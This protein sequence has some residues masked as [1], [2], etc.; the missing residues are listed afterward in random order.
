MGLFFGT[1]GLRGEFRKGIT[2]KISFKVGN[3]LGVL[4][5]NGKVLIATDTRKS[6]D[7]L[8]LSFASGLMLAGASVTFVGVCPTA[9]VG[10]LCARNRFD[11]GVVISASHNSAEFNG[12]KIFDKNGKKIN[13]NIESEIERNLLVLKEK[14]H[15]EVGSFCYDE[16]LIRDYIDFLKETAKAELENGNDFSSLKIV[17]DSANGA[18][19]NIAAKIFKELG[20]EVVQV[21]NSPNG[22]NINRGVGVMFISTLQNHVIKHHADFGFAYDGDSDRVLAVSGDGK[23]VDGDQIVY[24]FAKDYLEKNKLKNRTVVGTV[25]TNLG[26]EKELND[27][28]IKLIRAN[29]GDKFVFEE[30][31]KNGLLVGGEPAGHVFVCDKLQT[32]DGIL[33]SLLLTCLCVNKNAKLEDLA[34]V[35]KS[36]QKN[37]NVKVRNKNLIMKSHELQTQIENE[38]KKLK[39]QG[40]LVVRASGTEELIRIMAESESESQADYA[41]KELEKLIKKIDN[42]GG[43]C[44]E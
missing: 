36:H 3:S 14:N 21:A 23:V 35:K 28:G 4:A 5:K 22:T 34:R 40:R 20:A 25:L 16:N 37:V 33:N 38:N 42:R 17:I 6:S 24:I 1:D 8:A 26:V 11:F 27:L 2:P 31:E 15:Y 12:I 7:V 39:N 19:S 30:L 41:S 18:A 10:F 9:G 29:V 32:G 43:L 44:V 13:E